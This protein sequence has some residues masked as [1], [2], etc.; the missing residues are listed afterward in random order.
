MHFRPPPLLEPS[1]TQKLVQKRAPKM[2]PLSKPL[3]GSSWAPQ[4]N[5]GPTYVQNVSQKETQRGVPNGAKSRA[6][7]KV[8]KSEFHT[9]FIM[10]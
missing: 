7:K 1:W 6:P 8:G 4:K 3:L 5:I 2:D 9:L 10:F